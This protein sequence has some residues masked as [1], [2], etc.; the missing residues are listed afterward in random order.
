MG[1]R[2]LREMLKW[3]EPMPDMI[4][5]L[6]HYVWVGGPLPEDRQAFLETWR[7]TNPDYTIVHWGN[8]N[9]SDFKEPMIEEAFKQR[10]WAKVADIVRLLAVHQQGGIYLDTD[11]EV[12][13]PLDNL[14]RNA[15]FYGFQQ[16]ESTPDWIANGAFGA[17][18]RHWFI[19]DALN[20][21]LNMHSGYWE[22]PTAFGPK[23]ITQL[24]REN[25]L[26]TYSPRGVK[27]KD[28]Y[29]CP[30]PVFYPYHWTETY[31]PNCIRPETV[32]VHHWAEVPSF[33]ANLPAPIRYAR[34]G[35]RAL[36]RAVGR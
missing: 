27:V 22:R 24:L 34:L 29:L 14:L 9:I 2:N 13:R 1:A 8:H 23:L 31:R 35:L 17:T 20:R 7:Q 28:V 16:I 32:A 4:P 33:Y 11:F 30:V 12:I 36:K 3:Q 19:R 15:C 6:L 18:P 21:L 26:Q 10:K 5:K 25:G